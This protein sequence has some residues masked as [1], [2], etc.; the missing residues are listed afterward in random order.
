MFHITENGPKPCSAEK[1]QCPYANAGQE[2]FSNEAEAV[3]FY[4]KTMSE[5]YGKLSNL[6]T[7]TTEKPV[8]RTA[9]PKAAKVLKEFALKTSDRNFI[10]AYKGRVSAASKEEFLHTRKMQRVLSS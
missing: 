2:H 9:P 10:N 8:N 3:Q 5:T 7:K 1:G 4:E 6:K